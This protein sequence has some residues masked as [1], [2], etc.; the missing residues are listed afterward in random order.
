MVA[1]GEMFELHPS[2]ATGH[3]ADTLCVSACVLGRLATLL[4]VVR[5]GQTATLKSSHLHIDFEI[6]DTSDHNSTFRKQRPRSSG[7]LRGVA[8]ISKSQI[9]HFVVWSE[10]QLRRFDEGM[11]HSQT[12]PLVPHGLAVM[13]EP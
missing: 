9:E 2:A 11:P 5:V 12:I 10:R 1:V 4:S 13:V 6:H 3:Q 8:S 7:A